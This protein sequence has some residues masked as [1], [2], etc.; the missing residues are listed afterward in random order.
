MITAG[1]IAYQSGSSHLE[2]PMIDSLRGRRRLSQGPI[3]RRVGR[4]M[5]ECVVCLWRGEHL[6]HP[7]RSL[8]SNDQKIRDLAGPQRNRQS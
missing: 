2:E 3:S 7:I 1:N 4:V 8:T 6:C 5:A